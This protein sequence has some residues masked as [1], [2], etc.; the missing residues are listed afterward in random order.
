MRFE[1]PL[2]LLL[3]LP[4]A[5]ALAL[6]WSKVHGMARSRKR[7]AFVVRFLLIGAILLALSGPQARRQNKGIATIFVV[8][9]SDSISDADK[10]L[11]EQ[12]VRSASQT[13]GEDDSVGIVAF[14]KDAVIDSAP[15]S[16]RDPGPIRSSIDGSAT[17]IAG[18]VRLASAS[19]PE[20]KARRIV[21]LTDGNE[22][23]S[24]LAEASQV[25]ASDGID[26]D[27]YTLGKAE[28]QGEA[29]IVSLEAPEEAHMGQPINLRVL[30]DSTVSQ[31]A[32]LDI[33]R[34]GVLFKRMPIRLSKGRSAIVTSD[35]LDTTGFHKYRATLRADVDT[36]TRN[37]I[38]LAFVSIRGRP[39]VLILQQKTQASPLRDSLTKNGI[40]AD[41]IGPESVPTSPEEVQGYDAV[42]FNDF[43]ASAITT[44]QMKL[45]QSAVRDSGVGF[46]M[47]GGE[48]SFLPGGYYNTP[49]ADVLPVDL[50]IRQRKTFPNCSVCIMCDTSGSMGMI[51]D[52][53]PKVRLAARAAE[54][55]VKLLSPNDRVAVAG[56]TDGIEFVAPMQSASNKDSIVPQIERLSVGGGGIYCRPSMEKG[57]QVLM[58]ESNP[59]R[60]FMLLSDGDDAEDQEGCYGIA[61]RMRANHITTS[62]VAIGDG[63]D[64]AF[65]RKLAAVGGGRFY[66]A[67]HANQLPAVMTQ[68]TA[69]MARSAIEEGA[70]LPKLTVG[71]PI[72][73]NIDDFPPLF[74]YCLSDGRPLARIGMRTGKDDPLLATWQYGLGTSIAF[75]SDAQNRWAQRWVGW[76]GFGAFWSQAARTISRRSTKNDY[77]VTVHN[78]GGKGAVE[79]KAFDSLGNPMPN[80]PAIVKVTTPSGSSRTIEMSEQA[81]GFY[82]GSF[83]GSEIGSYIV[84]VA[85]SDRT[86]GQRVSTSGFSIPYPP[87]YRTYRPN[88]PLLAEASNTT[89]GKELSK[90]EEALRP[91]KNPGTSITDLWPSL[92]FFA[93]FLL[94]FDVAIRR[95]ALP[96]GELLAK[97]WAF[98]TKRKANEVAPTQTTVDRL[99]QA[100]Q[101]S[102][103]SSAPPTDS[104]PAVHPEPAK[105]TSKTPPKPAPPTGSGN[106]AKSLLDAKK[107]RN[108]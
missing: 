99:H 16:R 19:F 100:K 102:K 56:S 44:D 76:S 79:L 45:V 17:D 39:K 51:E 67:K 32:N 15:G 108:P 9:L 72:I 23:T 55:T 96:F 18:A 52:G 31:N 105:P 59:V 78:E 82:N 91:A 36:D 92:L 95:L 97:T 43:N 93:L 8:D 6:T 5:I 46:A 74:A 65:L 71:E 35:H 106:A 101:R 14:G 21:L 70:F 60:H 50:N 7:L 24:D 87:E 42:I 89:S 86:G 73:S 62:V 3:A 66:L 1:Q 48:N 57:E 107:K 103:T 69:L 38:G 13:A 34:D 30:V 61:L 12:F 4:L 54:E 49:I 11:S 88:T 83:E 84:T 58:T 90:P 53:A 37:N 2:Y 28:R 80:I 85:E 10:K 68:D 26:I 81:P 98:L 22:T 20:G 75:T 47:I 25:A 64:V 40:G 63:K 41:L 27:H 77:Q 104:P 33:D 29:A 94:P